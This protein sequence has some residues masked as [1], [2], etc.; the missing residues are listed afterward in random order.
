MVT[1]VAPLK[2]PRSRFRKPTVSDWQGCRRGRYTGAVKGLGLQDG[3][4][5]E[6]K[7]DVRTGYAQDGQVQE[8]DKLELRGKE[9]EEDE[10]ID[11]FFFAHTL[12]PHDNY[13]INSLNMKHG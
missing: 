13:V 2:G 5:I 3:K 6:I 10:F 11:Q 7:R 8:R 4:F 9:E 12:I 1:T